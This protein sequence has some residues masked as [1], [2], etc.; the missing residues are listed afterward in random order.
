MPIH[1][2]PRP[3]PQPSPLSSR[4]TPVAAIALAM[5]ACPAWADDE[6]NPYY[7]GISQGFTTD[8]N[9]FRAPEGGLVV[10]D[11]ISSTGV[12]LG[13]DQ[14]IGR[15]RFKLGV[16]ADYNRY[17]HQ[18]Q[19]N[20]TDYRVFGQVDWETVENLSGQL[21]AE[22]R[23]NQYRENASGQN[24]FTEKNLVRSSLVSFQIRLGLVS[25]WSLEGGGTGSQTHYSNAAYSNRDLDQGSLNAGVRWRPS[26]DLSVRLGG[27]HAEGTYVNYVPQE[28]S[29]KRDDIDLDTTWS[30]TGDSKLNL[31]VSRTRENHTVQSQRDTTGWTGALGWVWRATGK[32]TFDVGLSSDS[33]AG[34][35][36]FNGTLVDL[37]SSDTRESQQARIQAT[38]EA[39]SKI[40]VIARANHTRRT[41]DNAFVGTGGGTALRE[42]D[43]TSVFGLAL[44]YQPLRNL[45]LGCELSREQRTTDGT[46][47]L[48]YPYTANVGTCSAQVYLR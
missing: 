40:R 10:R 2:P 19:L 37:Q 23:L 11:T 33:S 43:R 35:T 27:R 22:Q 42:R 30:A 38:W 25:T 14:P 48:T 16:D 32:T 28:D 44:R 15:Q 20:H 26:S 29:F 45:D 47:I 36:D 8:D 4:L 41:L 7:L 3:T 5:L 31:R 12:R 13:L 9:L 34:S 6:P 17:S 1:F 21:L 24:V 18:S 39:T 46:G